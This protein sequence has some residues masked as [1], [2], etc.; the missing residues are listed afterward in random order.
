[1]R[2]IQLS[3]HQRPI[4]KIIVNRDGDLL[5][6][7]SKDGNP[8]AWFINN[9]ERL[10]TYE[11]HKGAIFDIAVDFNTNIFLSA[12]ADCKM[13]I[14]NCQTGK[15][16]RFISPPKDSDRVTCCDWACGD[17]KFFMCTLG[18]KQAQIIVFDFNRETFL[19]ES[20]T[21][22]EL[23]SKYCKI[24]PQ[25][26]KP[27][28]FTGHEKKIVTA[29]WGP[30]NEK[31]YTASE[32]GTIRKWDVKKHLEVKKVMFNDLDKKV[33]ITSMSFNKDKT[34]LIASGK[35]Q[36]ARLFDL[37]TLTRLKV[38][39][40]DKPLNCAIIHP[41]INL[42]MVGGGQ[43]AI[44]VTTTIHGKGKF[45]IQF[46]HTILEEKIGEIRT[47]HFSPINAI[48]CTNDGKHFITGAEEGNC[49]IFKFDADFEWKFKNLEMELS[50][51]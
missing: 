22:Y 50:K 13:G 17:K 27:D 39:F 48:C 26:S 36:T 34:L 42:V 16:Y 8:M 32:D 21:N 43:A 29:L 38:F 3:G 49:R 15:L 4:T 18:K 41:K 47:G 37:E 2:P 35:D 45:E 19:N 28:K 1:M 20:I 10:G 14:W 11:G 46:F 25:N 23:T 24:F 51:A 40:S 9:G 5:F 44:D 7:A 31:I 30:L 33:E 12:G 6:T